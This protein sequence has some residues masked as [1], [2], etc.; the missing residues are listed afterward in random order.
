MAFKTAIFQQRTN[1]LLKE[2][3][4]RRRGFGRRSDGGQTT[5]KA[6]GQTESCHSTRFWNDMAGAG[7]IG[8]G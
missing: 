2:L 8:H 3:G 7:T 5:A 6:D 4:I 1:V